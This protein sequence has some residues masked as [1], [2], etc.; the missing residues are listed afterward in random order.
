MKYLKSFK[1]KAIPLLL[2]INI[3]F[4]LSAA[5]ITRVTTSIAA[6]QI[7][8]VNNIDL[9]RVSFQ[10]EEKLTSI[11]ASLRNFVLVALLIAL[12]FVILIII[13]WSLFQGM[14]YSLLG[15]KKFNLKFFE[16]FLLLN[17]IWF[18]PWLLLLGIL[19]I[20]SK[21]ASLLVVSITALLLFLHFSL[22][23]YPLFTKENK[24]KTIKTAIRLGITKIHYFIVPYILIAITFMIIAQINRLNLYYMLILAI[25]LLFFS[26]VQGYIA[27]IAIKIQ[28]V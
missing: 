27:D 18:I 11:A 25:Y 14:I 13:A 5:G 21:T 2:I 19:L 1:N 23:L 26:W 8:K 6:P 7:E 10:T 16:K 9:S 22:I 12:L 17:L 20:G 4:I 28:K 3:L 15:K 24:L